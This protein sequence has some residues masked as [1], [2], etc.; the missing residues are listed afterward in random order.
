MKSFHVSGGMA[1]LLCL[2]MPHA[3]RADGVLDTSFGALGRFIGS[4]DNNNNATTAGIVVQPDGRILIGTSATLTGASCS[5]GFALNRLRVNATGLDSGF[6]NAGVSNYCFTAQMPAGCVDYDRL[7]AMAALP[8]GGA[9]LAGSAFLCSAASGSCSKS[10]VA[11]L[12]VNGAGVPDA[13]FNGAGAML[14]GS[15]AS[16]GDSLNRNALDVAVAA[17]GTVFAVGSTAIAG[18][19]PASAQNLAVWAV[20][21]NG[22]LIRE[23]RESSALNA[24]ATAVGLQPD[25]KIIVAGW[26]EKT[27]TATNV[28]TIDRDCVISRYALQGTTLARD[29]SFGTGGRVTFAFDIGGNGATPGSAVNDD[30]CSSVAVQRDG[31]IVFAGWSNSD[32]TGGSRAFTGRLLADGGLDPAF[33]SGNV[34]IYYFESGAAGMVNRATKVLVQ[35]DGKIVVSGQ[36]STATGS[37][38]AIDFGVVRFLPDASFDYGGFAGTSPGSIGSRSMVDFSPLT[39]ST[40]YD[41]AYTAA[42]DAGRV[43]IAG[44]ESTFRVARLDADGIFGNAFQ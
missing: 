7:S 30:T 32:G 10:D 4:V 27:N 13:A 12:R 20:D 18:G 11:L 26:T 1:L 21:A 3:S 17:N 44:G 8:G 19:F 33:L 31:R 5:S 35:G 22:G 36:A 40:S 29:E 24:A 42:F 37:G 34:R 2:A 39:G 43:V 23:Y 14:I 16:Y 25:G 6:G 41:M 28:V 15:G 9:L 38:R